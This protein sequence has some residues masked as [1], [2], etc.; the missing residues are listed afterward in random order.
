M[1]DGT[2]AAR[3][4]LS[5]VYRVQQAGGLN[6]GAGHIMDILRGKATEKVKQFGH[7]KLSTFGIGAQFSEPQLRSVLRQLI[8]TGALEV[9]AAA[10]NTLHLTE[11]SRAV[12]KGERP[13]LLRESV[14]QPAGR[15]R[16][17][18]RGRNGALPAAAAALGSEA[19]QRFAALKSW[20]AQVAKAHNLPAYVIFHDATL[21]AIAAAEPRSLA[22]LQGI[23]GIGERKLQAYG[24]DLL[25]VSLSAA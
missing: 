14:A 12:L 21:A 17:G 2:E 19:Q 10:F 15:S 4:L 6:F 20:R 3:M 7:E 5:T 23:A 9:D 13:V 1:W 16:R 22:D 25:R 24:E 18:E 11:G 8:A